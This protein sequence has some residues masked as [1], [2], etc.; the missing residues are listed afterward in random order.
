MNHGGRE[1]DVFLGDLQKRRGIL[2]K[3]KQEQLKKVRDGK[4]KKG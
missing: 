4:N 2:E 3:N 1:K